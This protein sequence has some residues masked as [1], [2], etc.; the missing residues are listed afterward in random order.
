M[1]QCIISR[2]FFFAFF[3]SDIIKQ[4][5]NQDLLSDRVIADTQTMLFIPSLLSLVPKPNGDLW[6]IIHFSLT[7]GSFIHDYIP[8]EAAKLKYPKLK[9]FLHVYTGLI[10]LQ[11]SSKKQSKRFFKMLH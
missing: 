1:T 9:I 8:K 3:N 5:L 10:K 6:R 11:V 4:K 7:R 2:N